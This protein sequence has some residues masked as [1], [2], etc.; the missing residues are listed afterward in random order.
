MTREALGLRPVDICTASGIN[1]SQYS[2]YEAGVS[3]P[4]AEDAMRYSDAFNIS[5]DWIFKGDISKL[6]FDLATKIR[7]ILNEMEPNDVI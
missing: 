4:N 7:S 3:R 5:M 2:N 6:S 1:P